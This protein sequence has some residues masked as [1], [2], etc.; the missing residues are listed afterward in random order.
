MKNVKPLTKNA[1]ITSMEFLEGI[2]GSLAKLVFEQGT[3]DDVILYG[4]A[5]DTLKD[6]KKEDQLSYESKEAPHQY[7]L[8]EDEHKPTSPYNH[9][10]EPLLVERTDANIRGNS[11]VGKGLV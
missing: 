11:D 3:E 10:A 1:Q 4:A 5:L 8:F 7:Y 6:I 9:Q 2:L